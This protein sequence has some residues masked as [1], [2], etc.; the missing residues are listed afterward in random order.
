VAAEIKYV[1]ILSLSIPFMLLTYE[2]L[3]RYT[4]VGWILNGKKRSRKTQKLA[5]VSA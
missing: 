5:E 1:L 3:V 2:L 4:F